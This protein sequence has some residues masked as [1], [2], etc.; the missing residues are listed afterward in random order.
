MIAHRL[1]ALSVVLGGLAVMLLLGGG[2]GGDATSERD[3]HAQTEA[4]NGK[5]SPEESVDSES[6]EEQDP[7]PERE[8]RE[9]R[10]DA[11]PDSQEIPEEEPTG[12]DNE[13]PSP[14]VALIP[15][16]EDGTW[17]ETKDRDELTVSTLLGRS[18]LREPY[19][20]ALQEY[21]FRQNE[22]ARLQAQAQ[23]NPAYLLPD[24]IYL[25]Y[26]VEVEA[27]GG[28][29]VRVTVKVRA[30]LVV[31]R[32]EV[33]NDRTV[34]DTVPA[35]QRDAVIEEITEVLGDRALRAVAAA[36]NREYGKGIPYRILIGNVRSE[37]ARAAIR[38]VGEALAADDS[39]HHWQR[40][41]DEG[42]VR[43]VVYADSRYADSVAF[44]MNLRSQ[45][46][47]AG[48]SQRMGSQRMEGRHIAFE[49]E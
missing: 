20:V 16:R 19:R 6:S 36:Y 7:G 40:D 21:S 23:E 47:E 25:G 38:A 29:E 49:L 1:L 8:P 42:E 44:A 41:D 27:L 9:E 48:Y 15:F 12:F 32:D 31:L 43:F 11:A 24:D 28:N 34:S 26:L 13:L 22:F 37:E 46:A 45:L 39:V 3:E 10:E 14:G 2:C 35:T 17:P 33:F 5:D 4:G 18:L 30:L